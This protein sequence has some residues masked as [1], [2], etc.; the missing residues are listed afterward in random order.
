MRSMIVFLLAVALSFT[1]VIHASAQSTE[2]IWLTVDTTAYKT[3]ETVVVTLHA[4]SATPIQ[5]FTFQIRYDPACL[6]P[7]NA[8][9]Q[10]PGMN[11]LPLPQISGLAD[12][13]YA[14]TTPQT[15]N[16]VLA[17]VRFVTLGGCQTN[18][19]LES[20]ALA[21]RN[22]SGFAAPLEKVTVARES[23]PLIIDK[24]LG[25]ESA[26]SL[27]GSILPLE[28]PPATSR[29]FAIW[30]IILSSIL[31][32]GGIL[33]AAFKYLKIGVP[34]APKPPATSQTPLLQIKH[35]PQSG[36]SFALDKLPCYIGRDPENEICLDDPHIIS[37][38]AKVFKAKNGYFL[39]DL[40][41]ETFING[42]AVRQSS[43]SL[44]PG[45]VVRLGKSALFVFGPQ[46]S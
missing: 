7:V 36:K 37:Q 12:G 6:K 26:E 3:R 15:I 19:N 18:L 1:V 20:A 25:E 44:K 34:F 16:G 13:S 31:L 23:V 14:S 5:G 24:A 4:S 42:R 35:G 10:V 40:G 32:I 33:F 2:N 43:A 22:E 9:S 45:D 27:S 8:V 21:I 29:G 38:H 11:A 28:P 17:E 39:M 46:Q 30:A 41:G